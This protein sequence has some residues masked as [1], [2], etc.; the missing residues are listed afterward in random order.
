MRYIAPE[1]FKHIEPVAGRLFRRKK[2]WPGLVVA[3]LVFAHLL[4]S[5][6]AQSLDGPSGKSQET[7]EVAS[8]RS[9][10]SGGFA[11]ATRT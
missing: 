7:F 1:I 10:V 6:A 3:L 4:P 2:S 8:I 9:D 11:G 5:A